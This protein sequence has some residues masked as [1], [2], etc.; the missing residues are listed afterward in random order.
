P[1]DPRQCAAHVR[2]PGPVHDG[3]IAVGDKLHQG[4]ARNLARRTLAFYVHAVRVRCVLAVTL[5]LALVGS[6][7][8]RSAYFHPGFVLIWAGFR[9]FFH[10]RQALLEHGRIQQQLPDT[11]ARSG[12]TMLPTEFHRWRVAPCWPRS[13]NGVETP[14]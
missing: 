2:V 4:I 14:R 12:E 11:L 1:A 8:G 9:E 7:D 6:A 10:A 5:D 3:A 13:A